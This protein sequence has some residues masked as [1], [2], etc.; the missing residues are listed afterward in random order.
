MGAVWGQRLGRQHSQQMLWPPL[1]LSFEQGEAGGSGEAV[2]RTPQARGAEGEG[3]GK[4]RT[5]VLARVPTQDC[6]QG[7]PGPC[8]L[9]TAQAFPLARMQSALPQGSVSGNR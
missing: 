6:C 2:L 9:D 3:T 4:Q 1:D 7:T 8:A 5:V